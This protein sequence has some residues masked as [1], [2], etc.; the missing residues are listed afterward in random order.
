MSN[1][2]PNKINQTFQ[3]THNKNIK[4]RVIFFIVCVSLCIETSSAFIIHEY[5]LG[6]GK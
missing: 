2:K 1:K 6:K 4:N 5:Y 3:L